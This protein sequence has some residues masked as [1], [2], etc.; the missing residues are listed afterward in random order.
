[1]SRPVRTIVAAI[2]LAAL[3]VTGV[4]I[5]VPLI[6]RPMIVAAVQSESPFG[7][8]HLQIDVD[9]NVFG[10][11]QGSIDRIHVHGTD[12]ARGNASGGNVVVGAVDVT[13]TDV[14]TSGHAF[15]GI[16][17]TLASIDVPSQD[18][19]NFTVDQV[20]L[21]GSSSNLSAVASLGRLAAVHLIEAAFADGGVDVSGVELGSGTVG[22]EVFGAKAQA[23]VGVENGALVLVDPFGQG[24]FE[25]L[26]PSDK[27]GWRFT[28]AGI[29]PDGMSIQA[30]LDV[31]KLL[32]GR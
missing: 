15:R 18:G 16:S 13:L 20:T 29:T 23:P 2:L 9:C 30:T 11:L 10:L 27:D 17:G 26:A 3:I 24:S 12:L 32:A 22:F 31:E 28:G 21:D 8:E 25:I 19:G 14:A 7:G 5:V 1:M 4:A 6:A